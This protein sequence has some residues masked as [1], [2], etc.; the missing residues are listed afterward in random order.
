MQAQ[1][2]SVAQTR[3]GIRRR[4]RSVM[5]PSSGDRQNMIPMDSALMPPSRLSAR[6]EPTCAR[7]YNEKY[8]EIT[9]IE[10]MTL[11]RSYSIQLMT[12]RRG[13]TR[14]GE[15]IGENLRGPAAKSHTRQRPRSGAI[16]RHGA[17]P[18]NR[19]PP[20]IE[21]QGECLT[22]PRSLRR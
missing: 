7:T 21:T 4:A 5:A 6:S 15:F 12:A 14:V 11:A 22:R 17:A 13:I 9:P 2:T 10:K 16:F 19:R 8:S 18:A 3:K 20:T 1:Q